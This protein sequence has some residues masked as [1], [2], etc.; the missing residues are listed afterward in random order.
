[1][2]LLRRNHPIFSTSLRKF[3]TSHHLHQFFQ[4]PLR[5]RS[6]ILVQG[7]DSQKFL[8]NLISNDI[9]LLRKPSEVSEALDETDIQ[10]D[11]DIKEDMI[12]TGMFNGQVITSLPLFL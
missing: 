9:S 8:Q 12:Y 5:S 7:P 2:N 1:M 3:S 4:A 10:D 6:V 11:K